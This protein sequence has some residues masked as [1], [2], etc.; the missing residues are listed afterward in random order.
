MLVPQCEDGYTR[1]ANELLEAL[2][3][4]R[5]PGESM[6]ILLVIIRKTYGFGKKEDWIAF[7]QFLETGI[8]KTHI[9][10]SLDKL[11][12]MNLV[13]K[14]GNKSR[15]T[16]GVN[17][18]YRTWKALPKKV[19]VTKKGNNELPKKV[20]TKEKVTKEKKGCRPPSGDQQKFFAWWCF[21]YK[22]VYGQTY[23]GNPGADGSL[24]KQLLAKVPINR[25]I[26]T[27][28]LM[29]TSK[30][31]FYV[32]KCIDIRFFKSQFDRIK[33]QFSAETI[34]ELREIGIAPQQGVKFENWK[35]W[36]IVENE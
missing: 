1:I 4:I 3:R 31:P 22:K 17:K 29:M 26:A 13:T 8:V 34:E 5:I 14:K 23:T 19:T 30:D 6:Q 25:M 18:D 15:I 12:E 27:A 7:S 21:A 10:R 28:S 36:E 11:V 32:N 35:F 20:L 16:Y 2:S 9:S 33:C 24:I